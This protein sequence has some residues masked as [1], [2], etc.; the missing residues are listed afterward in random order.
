MH[1]TTIRFDPVVWRELEAAARRRGTSSAQYVREATMARLA[2][3][4][5]HPDAWD[6]VLDDRARAMTAIDVAVGHRYAAEAVC[7]QARLARE[8]A[9]VTREASNRLQ[10]SRRAA[11]ATDQA[12]G[13]DLDG[14]KPSP[15]PE[16]TECL[17]SE[18]S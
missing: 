10:A 2:N 15:P 3:E 14:A 13:G 18:V 1:Q 9:R 17:A 5:R 8:R 16:T 7:A 4:T 11:R 12:T 6:G